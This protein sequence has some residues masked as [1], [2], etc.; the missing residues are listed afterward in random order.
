MIIRKQQI[1]LR[2]MGCDGNVYLPHSQNLVGLWK[3]AVKL[4]KNHLRRIFE[5]ISLISEGLCSLLV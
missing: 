2:K 4:V 5:N 1:R 3:A